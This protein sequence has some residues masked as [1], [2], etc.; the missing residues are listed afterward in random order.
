MRFPPAPGADP[1]APASAGPSETSGTLQAAVERIL[2]SQAFERTHRLSILL[3]YLTDH[4]TSGDTAGLKEPI[5]GQRVFGRP[6]DYIASDDNIVRSNVRQLRMKLEE[7]YASEGEKDPW[8]ITVPKGSYLLKLEPAVQSAPEVRPV[9]PWRLPDLVAVPAV[10]LAVVALVWW[11]RSVGPQPKDCLLSLLRPGPGQRLLVVGSDANVQ[12]YVRLAKRRVTLQEYIGGRYRQ[13]EH[14]PPGID[15]AM[16]SALLASRSVTETISLNIL[17]EFARALPTTSLSVLAAD[18]ITPRDFD[19]DNAVLISGPFGNPW[20]QM[21]DRDLNFQIE[22]DENMASTWVHNRKPIA[23]EQEY[24][25]NYT[26][27]SKTV[28]C[29]A[30][31][32]YLP[33]PRPGS[34][35]MLAGGPHHASTQAAGQFLTREDSLQSIRRHLHVHRSEPVP[36]FEAVVESRT[37]SQDPISMRIVAIRRVEPPN[38][39]ET[40]R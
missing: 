22:A 26:D 36:W 30:R 38:A 32:A 7:Y 9:R 34:H 40:T 20:V 6:A 19:H 17:P 3:R 37:L 25:R 39:S 28:V 29:Y 18:S 31:L 14:L 5:I 21:F 4:S 16:F 33:G 23:G 27:A 35:V 8:R 2:A 10:L 12:L 13:A 11:L 15:R 1:A 24:F